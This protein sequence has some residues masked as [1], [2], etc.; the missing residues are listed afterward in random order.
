MPDDLPDGAAWGQQSTED[1]CNEV[2]S[3]KAPGGKDGNVLTLGDYID[4]TPKGSISKVKMHEKVF[5]T[6]HD[7]RV[8]LLG[9]GKG[10]TIVFYTKVKCCGCMTN[11][12]VS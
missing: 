5:E 9:D 3:Y 4:K 11:S 12:C 1:I 6:W 10:G 8:V 2:Q 7:G